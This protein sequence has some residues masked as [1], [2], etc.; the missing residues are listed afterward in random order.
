M[1]VRLGRGALFSVDDEELLAG[2]NVAAVGSSA[3]GWE[4]IQFG[5]AELIGVRTFR[6]S[7]LLRGQSGS[8]PEMRQERLPGERFVLLNTAVVQPR[9]SLQNAGLLNHWKIGPQQYD[10]GSPS[11]V[12]VSLRGA[13]LGLRP[14]APCHLRATRQGPDVTFSW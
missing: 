11:Y 6:L 13:M 7:R 5:A 12:S 2:A 4:I 3:T 9:L 8:E 10:I 14:W 1:D